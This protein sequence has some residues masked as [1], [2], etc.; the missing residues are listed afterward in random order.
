M[1]QKKAVARQL[2]GRGLTVRQ[3]AVQLRCSQS[4]VRRVRDE[5]SAA[6]ANDA[7][8]NGHPRARLE[9]LWEVCDELDATLQQDSLDRSLVAKLVDAL[10]GL[11][12]QL[13]QSIRDYWVYAGGPT[14]EARAAASSL[15]VLSEDLAWIRL[16]QEERQPA[17]DTELRDRLG[18]ALHAGRNGL[19]LLRWAWT[20]VEKAQQEQLVV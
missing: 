16:V 19:A 9:A 11:R 17:R 10:T 8:S 2:L 14:E 1:E 18:H 7:D 12:R 20:P 4:V 5:A 6:G 13:T 15:A 3:V